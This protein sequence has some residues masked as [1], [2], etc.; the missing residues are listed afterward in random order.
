[1]PRLF[2]WFYEQS[3][4]SWCWISLGG[5]LVAAG[6]SIFGCWLLSHSFQSSRIFKTPQPLT[7]TDVVLSIGAIFTNSL[8]GVIGWMLWHQGSIVI[9]HTNLLRGVGDT[10]LLI[11]TMDIAMYGLHRLAHYPHLFRLIHASHHVHEST[12]PLSLFVLNPFEVL[13]FGF[14]LI[15]ALTLYSFSGAAVIAYLAFNLIFGTIGHLGVE[16]LPADL[17]RFGLF[18]YFGTSTFHGLHHANRA[19]NFGFYTTVWD[20]LFKTLDPH[21]DATFSARSPKA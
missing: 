13:G 10:L 18:R 3:F 11:V 6:V 19:Y 2:E 20:R 9:H 17:R 8:I 1:M 12:N 15:T 21:Y 7:L 4:V 5:N 14:L 16:P